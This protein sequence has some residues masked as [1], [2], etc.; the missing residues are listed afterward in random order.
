MIGVE[1]RRCVATIR[2]VNEDTAIVVVLQTTEVT[3]GVVHRAARRRRTRILDNTVQLI[4]VNVEQVGLVSAQRVTLIIIVLVADHYIDVVILA[5]SS[6][7]GN[8]LLSI[9]VERTT[10]RLRQSTTGSCELTVVGVRH[11]GATRLVQTNTNVET[12]LQ[13]LDDGSLYVCSTI[14][15]VTLGVALVQQNLRQ[16]VTLR[17]VR[18]R[19]TCVH[20]ITVVVHSDTVSIDHLRAVGVTQIYGIDR[21]DVRSKCEHVTGRTRRTLVRQLVPLVVRVRCVST[22]RQPLLSLIISAQTCGITIHIG[23]VNDT[24]VLQVTERTV[25]RDAAA[26]TRNACVVLLTET[27]RVT[28]VVPVVS[29]QQ[30]LGTTIVHNVTHSST[31]VNLTV[32]TDEVLVRRHLEDLVSQTAVSR[33]CGDHL[34]SASVSSDCVHTVVHQVVV[35]CCVV[36]LVVLSGVGDVVVVLHRLAG[37]A[38]L[39]ININNRVAALRALGGD[40]YHTVSTT[41][42]IQRS[43]GSVLLNGHRLDVGGVDVVQVAIV[44]DTV[45]HVQRLLAGV[46]RR[47]T[48]DTDRRSRTGLTRSIYQLQTCNLTCERLCNV[49]SLHLSDVL[50]L[51]LGCR[52]RKSLS[53]SCTERRY[54]NVVN[55]LSLVL[56]HNVDYRT[57]THCLSLSRETDRRELQI[58]LSRCRN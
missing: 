43:R 55:H 26:R 12:S 24:L 8:Q 23:V 14:E 19:Q 33:S 7:I 41:S 56:H 28:L 49:R 50:S 57:L 35:Q 44:G 52:T 53:L 30:V 20:T 31:G 45:H 58:S 46:D 4:V 42:T 40:H 17:Q 10:V 13:A 5:E 9:Q 32:H 34:V 54:D 38:P 36:D 22:D 15:C 18:T 39:S 6:I 21:S 1:L 48:T 47:E 51:N 3:L 37:Y 16:S 2:T 27:G 11:I 29:G 25:H